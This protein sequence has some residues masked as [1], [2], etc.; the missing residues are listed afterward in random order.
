MESLLTSARVGSRNALEQEP[1]APLRFVDPDFEQAGGCDVAMLVAKLVRLA[2][3]RG[4]RSVVFA[5]LGEH[6]GRLDVVRV[7]VENA[8][9]LRYLTD[10][11]QGGSAHFANPLGN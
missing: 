5:Q 6:V 10:R 7:I 9:R 4:E 11:L 1:G 8:L 3:A 2:H